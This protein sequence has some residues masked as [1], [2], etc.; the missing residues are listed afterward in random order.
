MFLNTFSIFHALLFR[1]VGEARHVRPRGLPVQG[2]REERR[3]RRRELLCMETT[4][5]GAATEGQ[6]DNEG[7]VRRIVFLKIKQ[8]MYLLKFL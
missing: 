5:G 4:E 1:K 3:E 8:F 2:D 7:K 6:R